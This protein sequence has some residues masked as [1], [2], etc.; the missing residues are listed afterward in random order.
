[1]CNPASQRVAV[2]LGDVAIHKSVPSVSREILSGVRRS[3]VFVLGD[4]TLGHDFRD[5]L[6]GPM[7]RVIILI[8]LSCKRVQSLGQVGLV[9]VSN[10]ANKFRA[11]FRLYSCS[12]RTGSPGWAANVGEFHVRGC[13]LVFSSSRRTISCGARALHDRIAHERGLS[14]H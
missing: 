10:E 4:L 1:M 12:A 14:P 11:R 6:V 2:G 9:C 13:K 5:R 7:K 8:P 3:V